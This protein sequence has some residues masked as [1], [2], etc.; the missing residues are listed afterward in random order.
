MPGREGGGHRE[1]AKCQSSRWARLRSPCSPRRRRGREPAHRCHLIW[2]HRYPASPPAGVAAGC[3]ARRM[4][5]PQRAW[6]SLLW[7]LL[8]SPPGRCGTWHRVAR[9]GRRGSAGSGGYRG[10]AGWA[11]GRVGR[12]AR[13][14]RDVLC[15]SAAPQ[16]GGPGAAE[17]ALPEGDRAR[18][19]RQGER[20]GP[21]PPGTP[22][23]D[24]GGR[25]RA[26]HGFAVRMEGTSLSLAPGVPG[27]G[28]LGHQQH[29]GGGEGAE[30]ERQRAGPDAVPG[31]SATLQVRLGSF[32]EDAPAPGTAG[33]G[34]AVGWCL[35]P[36]VPRSAAEQSHGCPV[37]VLS[38]QH[39]S[40]PAPWLSLRR[41]EGCAGCRRPWHGDSGLR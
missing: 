36:S 21:G 18:L 1:R 35:V 11:G 29:P 9:W 38:G 6:G 7:G 24:A 28:E 31:G 14:Q 41:D 40:V 37:E 8:R 17:P 2:G 5:W 30:G 3:L 12:R 19:V 23:W 33:R 39:A 15:Y 20:R 22:R 10:Q 27:G 34:D 4:P 25:D 13:G 32:R 16:V 26:V